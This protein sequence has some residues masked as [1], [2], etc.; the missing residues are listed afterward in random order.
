MPLAA[1]DLLLAPGLA[2]DRS[3]G[4]LGRGAGYYDRAL[5]AAAALELTVFG[6]AY[7]FQVVKRVP[8]EPHDR[9]MAGVITEE[10]CYRVRRE[11]DY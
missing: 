3:G 1:G 8:Q 5:E 7:S 4:R 11:G 10:G 2:F 6:L 9:R